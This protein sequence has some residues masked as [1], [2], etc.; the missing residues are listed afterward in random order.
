MSDSIFNDV[1]NSVTISEAAREYGYIPNRSGF[2]CC[3][4]HAEKTP[5]MKL[6]DRKYHCFGCGAHG[7][8]I[9]FVGGLFN[10]SPLD[11]AR[12][13]NTDFGLHLSETPPDR[14]EQ[15]R[16]SR[17]QKARTLFE[18]WRDQMLNQIDA[19]IR[20]ANTADFNDLTESEVTAI[21]YREV[22]E[23]YSDILL[24]E[25]LSEQMGVFRDRREVENL[26]KTILQ[27]M[28]KRLNTA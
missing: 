18:E 25:P 15:E 7:S 22:L 11:A 28:P 10:L 12:K 3:P 9:D 1:K 5:S 8:V 19:S 21:R 4:F 23:Y 24:H 26:C 2:I 17:T 16:H 20:I 13:L 14:E 27:N 6:Y